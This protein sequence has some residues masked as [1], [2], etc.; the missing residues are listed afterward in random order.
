[1]TER[2]VDRIDEAAH[3]DT[4]PD[5]APIE[6]YPPMSRGELLTLTRA[7]RLLQM[8]PRRA[9]TLFEPGGPLHQCVWDPF[10]QWP[11]VVRI[12]ARRLTRALAEGVAS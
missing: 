3:R 2:I 12:S 4:T 1:M 9:R 11:H 5:R 10:G 7:A 6:V 8:D